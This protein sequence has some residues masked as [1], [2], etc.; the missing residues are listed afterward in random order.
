M[1]QRRQEM[2]GADVARGELCGADVS[3]VGGAWRV[4]VVLTWCFCLCLCLCVSVSD[5]GFVS[6]SVS[7]SVSA[8]KMSNT[9]T[10]ESARR[11]GKRAAEPDS[12]P[13]S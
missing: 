8:Q 13:I 10:R 4:W 7:V 5:S 3:P 12:D 2:R 1:A 11:S 9:P 6:V